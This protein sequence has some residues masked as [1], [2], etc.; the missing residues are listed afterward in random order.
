MVTLAVIAGTPVPTGAASPSRTV[1][2][3]TTEKTIR[4]ESQKVPPPVAKKPQMDELR[5]STPTKKIITDELRY[6]TVPPPQKT[7][8][9]E[10]RY[11]TPPAKRTVIE[12]EYR[13]VTCLANFFLH[14]QAY[15][16]IYV[17]P[18]INSGQIK[19][20]EVLF[21]FMDLPYHQVTV[22]HKLQLITHFFLK[23]F[24]LK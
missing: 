16:Y 19:A 9:E 10:V 18:K 13:L 2:T 11:T 17:M 22:N 23:K 3:T 12:E 1:I 5:Y 7:V 4:T 20:P 14:F 8:I 15:Q 21:S 24:S 6:T